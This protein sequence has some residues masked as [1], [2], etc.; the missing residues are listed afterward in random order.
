[1]DQEQIVNEISIEQL[2]QIAGRVASLVGWDIRQR[3]MSV[4]IN[5]L[6]HD[7]VVAAVKNATPY[8]QYYDNKLGLTHNDNSIITGITAE[9]TTQTQSFLNRLTEDVKKNVLNLIYDNVSHINVTNVLN[10]Q[11][12]N[13]VRN[14]LLTN[15][16]RLPNQSIPAEAVNNQNLKLSADNITDGTILNFKSTGITDQASQPIVDI[17]DELTVIGNKLVVKNLQV[18]GQLSANTLPTP[19]LER[20]AEI[21]LNYIESK[22]PTGSFDFALLDKNELI[23]LVASNASKK[24]EQE[25]IDT[26]K[27]QTA[28]VD[29][30]GQIQQLIKETVG[31]ATKIYKYPNIEVSRNPMDD[32][33][34]TG[35]VSEFRNETERYFSMLAFEIEKK[36]SQEISNKITDYNFSAMIIEYVNNMI[37]NIIMQGRLNFPERS[38]SGKSINPNGLEIS[39]DNITKGLYRN[40]ESTGIQDQATQCQLVILDEATVFEN[41][42]VTKDLEVFGKVMFNGE[43]DETLISKISDSAVEKIE[44]NHQNGLYDQYAA[45][46]IE[47]LDRDGI[48]VDKIRI[49]NDKLVDGSTLNFRVTQSNLQKL[50]MLQELQVQGESL[51]AD[52]LYV[53]NRRIG[54]NT[55]DPEK[56]LDLWDQEVRLVMGKRSKDVGMIGSPINQQVILSSNLKNNLI[57]KPDGTVTIE[58]LYIGAIK[59]TSGREMPMDDRPVGTIVWNENP[60]IGGPIGW[61]SLGGARWASFGTIIDG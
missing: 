29:I 53:T 28:D 24:Y 55:K 52:T 30:R 61:V 56:V 13:I 32:T 57:L 31:N 5:Q 1:M 16:W 49:G 3:V 40:F 38:I 14:Y 26:V 4:D 18:T 27:Q 15:P 9:F 39:A 47:V 50:G 33:V 21:T 48:N 60:Y 12:E 20:I 44:L 41:K 45:K 25:V 6:I 59:H 17:T 42:L 7:E 43:V 46:V 11:V 19:I 8:Y 35:L 37:D 34:F 22:L 58:Q 36:I 51:L 10:E 54:I 23:N 2:D